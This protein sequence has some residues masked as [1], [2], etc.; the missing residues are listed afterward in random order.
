[1]FAAALAAFIATNLTAAPGRNILERVRDM[2][3]P[4]GEALYD[5]ELRLER[6]KQSA[7]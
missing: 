5:R 3:T 2:R 1:M 6:M 7:M 4:G